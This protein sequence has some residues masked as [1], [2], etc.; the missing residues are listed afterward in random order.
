M[1][2]GS[3]WNQ[4]NLYARK[5]TLQ[6]AYRFCGLFFSVVCRVALAG[7]PADGSILENQSISGSI[8]LH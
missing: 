3:R 2:L 5:H 8:A 1:G 6:L 4:F 7:I